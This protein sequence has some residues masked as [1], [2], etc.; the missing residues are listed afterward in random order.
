MGMTR[1]DCG[2]P[3]TG[4]IRGVPPASTEQRWQEYGRQLEENL[5]RLS[6]ALRTCRYR[7]AAVRRHD[8]AKSNGRQR[9]IGLPTLE[10][11]IVQRAT[12]EV[13]NA[14]YEREFKGF[15]SGFRPGG[16]QH[17]ALDAR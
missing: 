16:N 13:L 10:D 2:K 3:R 6:A 4:S 12:T 17:R 9:P 7:A 8:L 1:T 11:K 15:S 5:H 14:V